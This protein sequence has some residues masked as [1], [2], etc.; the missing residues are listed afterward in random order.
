MEAMGNWI[1]DRAKLDPILLLAWVSSRVDRAVRAT[2]PWGC[3]F[4][5]PGL[6]K[7]V[8]PYPRITLGS[9]GAPVPMVETTF[10]GR[11][12][13]VSDPVKFSGGFERFWAPLPGPEL[14]SRLPPRPLL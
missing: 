9:V 14:S 8:V 6:D 12:Q 3:R 10:D 2:P 11:S 13:A 7:S 5:V 4:R 1:D